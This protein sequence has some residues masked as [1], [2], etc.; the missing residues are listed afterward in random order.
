MGN[1]RW[2]LEEIRDEEMVVVVGELGSGVGERDNG[3]AI[4]GPATCDE[5]KAHRLPTSVFFFV[6]SS[7]PLPLDTRSSLAKSVRA[8]NAPA[9]RESPLS[10]EVGFTLPCV[11]R[12]VP[13][14]IENA[15]GRF[16]DFKK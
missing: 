1:R 9:S 6:F 5:R 13:L 14:S 4:G 7:G 12:P 16:R 2:D 11:H 10:R 3:A 8:N 15:A